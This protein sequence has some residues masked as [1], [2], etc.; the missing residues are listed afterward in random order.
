MLTAIQGL[1]P[2]DLSHDFGT[3]EHSILQ[4]LVHVYRAER[5]WLARIE[6]QVV[7]FRVEGDDTLPALASNWPALGQK[8]VNW[9]AALTDESAHSELTYRD[10]RQNPWT[11][12][13]WQIILHVVNHST[14]HRGQV[15]GFLRALGHTPPNTDSITFARQT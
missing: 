11:Q 14:H 3:S 1:T 4:T 9:S 8:W 5:M 10:L 12:P 15:A 7:D 6:G 13:L 2:G